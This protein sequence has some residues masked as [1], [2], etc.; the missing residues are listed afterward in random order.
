MGARPRPPSLSGAR[1]IDEQTGLGEVY[2]RSLLRAQLRLGMTVVVVSTVVIGVLPLLFAVEPRLAQVRLLTVP[3]PWWLIGVG[4]Y[5]VFV[6]LAWWYVRASER[7]ERD[8]A[9]IVERR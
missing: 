8:F 5:P 9:D 2:M 1:D 3:I 6:A 7:A 4:L